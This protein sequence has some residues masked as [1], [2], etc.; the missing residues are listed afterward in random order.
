MTVLTELLA[1]SMDREPWQQDMIR[2]LYTQAA[3]TAADVDDAYKML[4]AQHGL[5]PAGGAAGANPLKTDDTG[6][7]A[8]A[9]AGTILNSIDKIANCNRLAENQRIDFAIEGITLIYGDN[10][11]GKSGYCRMLKRICRVRET[12]R[13][14]ILGDAYKAR[15]HPPATVTVRHS[16]GKGKDVKEH[17]W[18]DGD[19]PIHEL[20]CVSVFDAKT[21]PIYANEEKKIEFLPQGLDVLPRLGTLCGKLSEKLDTEINALR[22]RVSTP[23][24]IMA[25]GT[26]AAALAARLT[27][28]TEPARLPTPEQ[29]GKMGEWTTE[30]AQEHADIVRALNSDPER[31]A[32]RCR[33]TKQ[34][35][36]TLIQKIT[37]V[38]NTVG[39]MGVSTVCAK[40]EAAGAAREAANLAAKEA[41]AG[42][43]LP[44]VGGRA[45]Q[46]MFEQARAYS[47]VAYADQEFPVT[48]SDKLCLLCQQPLKEEASD[49]LKR[50][51]KFIRQTTA[52]A[53]ATAEAAMQAVIQRIRQWAPAIDAE[54]TLAA[55]EELH[56]A[57]TGIKE[58]L[59]T[60][61]TPVLFQ[62]GLIVNAY[63][64]VEEIKRIAPLPAP[65]LD[66]LRAVG[67]ALDQLAN[68][69]EAQKD[70]AARLTLEK[71][72]ANLEAQYNFYQNLQTIRTRH[73]DLCI[74]N[75]TKKCKES[76]TSRAI[77]TKNTELRRQFLTAG[78][79][80]LVIDEA[81]KFG[82]AYLPLKI[83]D[84]SAAGES[85][86]G[87]NVNCHMDVPNIDI[88]SE[89]EFRAL[90]LACF[91]AEIRGL[92]HHAGIIID[93]PVSS[94]D[95]LRCTLVAQRLVEEAKHRQVIVFT[96]NLCFYYEIATEAGQEGVALHPVYVRKTEEGF[97]YVFSK[98]EPWIAKKV[99]QRLQSLEV[100]L[101]GI[102]KLGDKTGEPYRKQVRTF[103]G[104]LRDTWERFVEEVLFSGVVT[105]YEVGV[106]T[107]SLSQVHVEDSDYTTIYAGMARASEW[108]HD[109]A[110]ARGAAWPSVEMMR[111]EI[112]GLRDYTKSIQT[113]NKKISDIR[114]GLTKA[115]AAAI[116]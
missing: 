82:L 114:K 99:M 7:C 64:S 86:L 10:G 56:P 62:A 14:Q 38:E 77:S 53:A 61:L 76:C 46:L 44:G 41:F 1:F 12:A 78:F 67:V 2:R 59:R 79:E 75:Q 63:P 32:Q 9:V 115:P 72:K 108:C 74:L 5:I 18:K 88:L 30:M 71:R 6:H 23:L 85:L 91:F 28:S 26:D 29:I 112:D 35:V 100:Y 90:A 96:H 17:G 104:D 43:P 48:G 3:L 54:T 58:R 42:E 57:S 45:W 4:K 21:A 55:V 80:R 111:K 92:P 73:A 105:R 107:Q 20:S 49:R 36:E 50:F 25:A 93:D 109:R 22:R 87:V 70:P 68:G 15:S 69:Y 34:A 116:A 16:P 37:D 83:A 101:A 98:E 65:P 94:L 84:R 110:F 89:G 31:L 33:A 51:D 47:A 52:E 19:G 11:S 95:H 27:E 97:G 39:T 66:E 102:A 40:I 24:P 113:R 60:Y 103:Y 8:P 13:E 106:K 81:A